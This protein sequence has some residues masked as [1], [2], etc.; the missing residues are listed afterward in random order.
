MVALVAEYGEPSVVQRPAPY[1]VASKP[2]VMR[3][4]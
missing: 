1:D 4:C 3:R 2:L